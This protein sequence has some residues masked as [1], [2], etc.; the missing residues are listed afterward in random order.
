MY[1]SEEIR[2]KLRKAGVGKRPVIWVVHSMGGKPGNELWISQ[3]FFFLSGISWFG[4]YFPVVL[5]SN[6]AH[7][8]TF[9]WSDVP[10]STRTCFNWNHGFIRRATIVSTKICL[11]FLRVKA[12]FS[13]SGLL[14]K[15]LLLDA[16]KNDEFRWVVARQIC[17]IVNNE[18]RKL[19]TVV[20]RF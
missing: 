3:F 1:R 16:E 11:V 2:R 9:C 12:F 5:L 6:V 8:M 18:C 13:L 14:V 17:F 7:L 10:A 15:Q 19:F 4:S 20:N